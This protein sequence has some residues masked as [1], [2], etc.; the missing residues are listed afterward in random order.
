[1]W[2]RLRQNLETAKKEDDKRIIL[3]KRAIKRGENADHPTTK[4]RG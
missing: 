3:T 2:D 1:M 4:I